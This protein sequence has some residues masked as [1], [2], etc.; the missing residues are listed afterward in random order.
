MKQKFLDLEQQRTNQI[1][2]IEKLPIINATPEEMYRI[3]EVNPNLFGVKYTRWGC[4]FKCVKCNGYRVKTGGIRSLLQISK[5]VNEQKYEHRKSCKHPKW[6]E[7]WSLHRAEI[8]H[9]FVEQTTN[10]TTESTS[11]VDIIGKFSNS[12]I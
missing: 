12:N 6:E 11:F 8:A 3:A 1:F 9:T 7:K 4:N 2:E 10:Q 5:I